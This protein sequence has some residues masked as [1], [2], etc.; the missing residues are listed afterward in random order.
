MTPRLGLVSLCC[1]ADSIVNVIRMTMRPT[2]WHAVTDT[3]S[4]YWP[5]FAACALVLGGLVAA[6]WWFAR[7]GSLD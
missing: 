2:A 6:L 3:L 4:T 1:Q 7:R 5:Q